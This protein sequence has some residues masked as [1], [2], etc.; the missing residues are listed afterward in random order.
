MAEQRLIDPRADAR[1]ARFL[2][3]QLEHGG[4]GDI[5]ADKAVW[6]AAWAAAIDWLQ[7]DSGR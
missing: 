4:N 7:K 2:D 6:D 3:W 5:K 1:D